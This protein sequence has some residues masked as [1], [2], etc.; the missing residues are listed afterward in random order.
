MAQRYAGILG[1][2]AFSTIVLRGVIAGHDPESTLLTATIG[3]FAFA[4]AGWLL[5]TIAQ[6]TVEQSV[7]QRFEAGMKEAEAEASQTRPAV[8]M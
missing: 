7:R 4:A 3:L 5:G 8:K 2:I 6:S 1:L